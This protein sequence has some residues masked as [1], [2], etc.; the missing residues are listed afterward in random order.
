MKKRD[1]KSVDFVHIMFFLL[2]VNRKT[3]KNNYIRES[4]KNFSRFGHLNYK[5]SLPCNVFC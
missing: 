1:L 5:D 3:R 2:P 4:T